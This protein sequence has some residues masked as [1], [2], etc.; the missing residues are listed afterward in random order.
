MSYGQDRRP[1]AIPLQLRAAEVAAEGG[2]LVLDDQPQRITKPRRSWLLYR[3]GVYNESLN[4][5]P[6]PC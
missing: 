5:R 6:G 3:P 4:P 2:A 1:V